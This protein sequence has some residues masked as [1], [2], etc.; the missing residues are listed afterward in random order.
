M[1]R[2][3][4]LHRHGRSKLHDTTVKYDADLRSTSDH[5]NGNG[6]TR[7]N[8]KVRLATLAQLDKRTQAAKRTTAIMSG[9]T[10]D[11]GG[12]SEVTV[13]LRQLVQRAA[14]L[15]A[16]IE[17]V[18][19]RWL[20]TEKLDIDAYVAAVNTQRRVLQTIG[21]GRKARDLN[22]EDAT[23]RKAYEEALAEFADP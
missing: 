10:S 17:N 12:E 11:L 3:R 22:P 13:A 4:H 5:S 15:G 23:N 16:W 6:Q 9:L 2:N 21:M 7:T 14:L 19:C 8:G 18:E 1:S 20:Q